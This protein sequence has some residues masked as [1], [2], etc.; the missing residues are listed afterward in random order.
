M[1]QPDCSWIRPWRML[2][3]S[4]G[5]LLPEPRIFGQFSCRHPVFW[6]PLKHAPYEAK[7][8]GLLLFGC[9]LFLGLKRRI[10]QLCAVVECT[11]AHLS[12]FHVKQDHVRT[13]HQRRRTRLLPFLLREDQVVVV[14]ATKSSWRD[15]QHS[16]HLGLG[17]S[18]WREVFLH[19]DPKPASC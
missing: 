1:N 16:I 12:H 8:L 17:A 13:Y 5:L 10:G 9:V 19:A 6:P 7:K 4:Q 14:L 2:E 11:W 18:G 3:E 15:A